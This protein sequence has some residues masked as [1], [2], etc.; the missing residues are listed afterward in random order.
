MRLGGLMS[1]IITIH[2][3]PMDFLQELCPETLKIWGVGDGE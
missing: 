1:L 3:A 2:D